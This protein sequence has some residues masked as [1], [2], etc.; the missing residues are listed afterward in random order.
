MQ[1]GD[2]KH[3]SCYRSGARSSARCRAEVN[4]PRVLF[5]PASERVVRLLHSRYMSL[6]YLSSAFILTGIYYECFSFVKYRLITDLPLLRSFLP[7][8]I[9]IRSS[10]RFGG[11]V[12]APFTP[13][14]HRFWFL[15]EPN[16]E[17]FDPVG[18]LSGSPTHGTH[19]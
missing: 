15:L 6:H 9:K 8:D 1:P 10:L 2:T 19:K 7:D 4:I 3:L 17:E 12:S 18:G 13:L 5:S 14:D 16:D 11:N